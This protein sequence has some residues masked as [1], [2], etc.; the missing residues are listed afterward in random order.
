[1]KGPTSPLPRPRTS[2]TTRHCH[3]PKNHK[4]PP[5]PRIHHQSLRNQSPVRALNPEH[6]LVRHRPVPEKKHLDPRRIKNQYRRLKRQPPSNIQPHRRASAQSDQNVR[7]PQRR[8]RECPINM[9]IHQ[10]R[11]SQHISNL[12]SPARFFRLRPVLQHDTVFP[13]R[14]NTAGWVRASA[15]YPHKT[16]SRHNRQQHHQAISPRLLRIMNMTGIQCQK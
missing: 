10:P 8:H 11:A 9:R 2:H 1:M 3:R 12:K 5:A 15:Q 14:R 7:Q 6:P 13:H 16:P 4:H